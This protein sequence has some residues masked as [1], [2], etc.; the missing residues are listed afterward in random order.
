M[1]I[2]KKLQNMRHLYEQILCDDVGVEV[3]DKAVSALKKQKPKKIY[4]KWDNDY[5][6]NDPCCGICGAYV[7]EYD[8]YCNRCGQ[9]IDWGE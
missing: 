7:Q 1:E 4:K 2:F 6:K 9:A 5:G 8:K 3:I